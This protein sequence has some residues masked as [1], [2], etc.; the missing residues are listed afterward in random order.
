M[1]EEFSSPAGRRRQAR[2]QASARVQEPGKPGGTPSRG[3]VVAGAPDQA[4]DGRIGAEGPQLRPERGILASMAVNDP[5]RI[6][7]RLPGSTEPHLPNF[8]EA[9]RAAALPAQRR[10]RGPS[11]LAWLTLALVAATFALVALV[12]T[13]MLDDLDGRRQERVERAWSALMR[14]AGGNTGKAS[15]FNDLWSAGVLLD[16]LDLSCRNVGRFDAQAPRCR[17]APRLVGLALDYFDAAKALQPAERGVARLGNSEVRSLDLSGTVIER[18]RLSRVSLKKAKLHGT[19]IRDSALDGS[20]L[21]GSFR[22]MRVTGSTLVNAWIDGNIRGL[23]IEGSEVSGLVFADFAPAPRPALLSDDW[24]W[25]DMPPARFDT[26]SEEDDGAL[27][28]LPPEFLAGVR[29]CMPPMDKDGDIVPAEARRPNSPQNPACQQM[30]LEASKWL[31]PD[32]YG[33]NSPRFR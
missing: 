11:I 17:E 9:A 16:G 2:R 6:R 5:E 30:S 14:P 22:G 12:A 29:L 24:A 27:Q 23:R 25:A 26:E 3:D 33:Q 20:R 31:F 4:A 7:V 15:A 13:R 1:A 10:P 21:Q 28:P 8:P 18:A 19:E 32:V